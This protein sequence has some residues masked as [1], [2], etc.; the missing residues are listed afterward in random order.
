MNS[1]ILKYYCGTHIMTLKTFLNV[2]N[3]IRDNL[4]ILGIAIQFDMSNRIDG[5]RRPSSSS[6]IVC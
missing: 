1:E 4:V 6:A 5:L 3:I 2:A